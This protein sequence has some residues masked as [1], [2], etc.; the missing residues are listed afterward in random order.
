MK[1]VFNTLM[2]IVLFLG[3][4]AVAMAMTE[5]KQLQVN[6]PEEMALA[7]IG[8]K[9]I[10]EDINQDGIQLGFY[11]IKHQCNW[12]DCY[13]QGEVVDQNNFVSYWGCEEFTDGWCV[14]MTH[15]MNP[16][17]TYEECEAYVFSGVE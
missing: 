2:V 3:I 14:E 8:D 7:E 4:T 12:E 15:F 16:E 9:L 17:M 10:V 11:N 6:Y 1:Q 5:P 13:H